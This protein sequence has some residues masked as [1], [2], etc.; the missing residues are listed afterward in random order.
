MAQAPAAPRSSYPPV[1]PLTAGLAPFGLIVLVPLMRRR[2]PRHPHLLVALIVLAGASL[3]LG[4]CTFPPPTPPVPTRTPT[5]TAT[6][7]PTSTLT[8]TETLTPTWT[9]TP[10]ETPTPTPEPT[11]VTTTAI[12]YSYDPLYRLTAADYDSGEFFHYTYDG[13]GNRLTQESRIASNAYTYDAANRLTS[14][15]GVSQAWDANG[16]LLSDGQRTFTYDHANRLSSVLNGS[17]LYEFAY[18]GLGDRLVQT[19]NGAATEYT[20]DLEGGLTQVLDDGVSTYLYGMGR[21]AQQGVAGREYFLGDAL[22]STRQLVDGAGR[23]GLARAYQPYGDL[24]SIAGEVK[25]SYGFAGEWADATGLIHLRARYYQPTTGR[26]VQPD[27]FEGIGTK[28]VSLNPYPYAY[29]NP[30]IYT[31]ASGRNPVLALAAGIAG[32]IALGAA[33]GGVFGAL[34]YGMA[35]GNQCGCEMQ[36]RA[37]SMSFSDWVLENALA[38]GVLGA[39][40]AV[41]AAIGPIGLIAVGGAAVALSVADFVDTVQIILYESGPT[42]CTA[43][44]LLMDAVGMALGFT[45]A[46]A[47]ARAWAASGR[48]IGWASTRAEAARLAETGGRSPYAGLEEADATTLRSKIPASWGKPE[49]GY[50]QTK[51]GQWIAQ[52]KFTSPDGMHQIRVHEPHAGYG[53]S[54]VARVG[55]RVPAG[56]P[57]AQENTQVPGEW[58]LYFDNEGLPTEDLDIMHIKVNVTLAEMKEVFRVGE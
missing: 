57:G 16:N 38:G 15:D 1:D 25:T 9:P 48:G 26:F 19:V 41:I 37:S 45:T 14:V 10:T 47:G 13:V 11:V 2:Q 31:D 53:T 30:V 6:S 28:P 46:L 55:V 51:E 50:Y 56:Y 35:L 12:T 27:P 18:S 24:L 54:W 58:W 20:L 42:L 52:Y 22:S 34:T 4:A 3:S 43:L 32:G 36:Q 17:D 8:P 40:A 44:R 7:S 23:I 29:D 21:I 39:V 49:F 5:P 33:A